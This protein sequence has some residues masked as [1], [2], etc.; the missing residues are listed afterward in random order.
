MY[1]N[2]QGIYTIRGD[3][4]YENKLMANTA[5][6]ERPPAESICLTVSEQDRN[7]ATPKR[8]QRLRLTPVIVTNVFITIVVFSS[9]VYL[10]YGPTPDTRLGF[11]CKDPTI[12]L[13]YKG[14]SVSLGLILG[15]SV[16][17]PLLLIAFIEL[18]R[19]RN[20][21]KVWGIEIWNWFRDFMIGLV[22][23]LVFTQVGKVLIGEHRPHFFDTCL[24][25]TGLTCTPGEFVSEY[26]CTN[27][28]YSNYIVSD[29]SKSFPSGHASVSVYTS[30]FCAFYVHFRLPSHHLR[31]IIKPF[32]I[33]CI[34]LW[35]VVCCF[36][37]IT[38]YR[39]HWWD[40]LAGSVL[41]VLCVGY[42]I[43][44]MCKPCQIPLVSSKTHRPSAST[45]TL[46]DIKNKDAT[47]V[48][49]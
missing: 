29:S 15:G 21:N 23:N 38:D 30:L 26:K 27:E 48:I 35:S 44:S 25:D 36:T 28:F 42:T 11:Y 31:F 46:L 49:I 32:I 5:L 16:V 9:L 4:C 8:K 6:P 12:S 22:F 18:Y 37:R 2:H 43:V 20:F 7:S 14:D 41:G 10:E 17:G 47:S 13:P 19:E 45:T 33:V 3:M 34:L 40:V 24:P 39:H 1:N